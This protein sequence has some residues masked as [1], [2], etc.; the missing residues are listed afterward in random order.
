MDL[1]KTLRKRWALATALLILTLIATSAAL[2]KLPWSYKATADV[3]LLPSQNLAK[4]YGGNPFLAFNSTIN[5]T[6]DVIRY[7]A[8]NMRTAQVL[9][10]AGYTQ[11]YTI[12]DALD[13]SAPILQIT[14]T[15]SNA[16]AVEHT[17]TGVVNKISTLLASQQSNFRPANQIHDMVISSNPRAS[18]VASKKARP[19]LVVFAVGLLFTVVIPVLVDAVAERR[20]AF[21]R[22]AV[23]EPLT[24]G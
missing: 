7:E 8:T 22:G 9:V 1:M 3:T 10:A 23:R 17:L 14:V 18:R 19:L 2:V 21:R 4:A 13:T 16:G 20:G 24:L 5:E 12:T 6:A 11:G 15:G